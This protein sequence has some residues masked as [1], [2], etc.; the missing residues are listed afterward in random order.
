MDGNIQDL[1]DFQP[2]KSYWAFVFRPLN[3]SFPPSFRENT[4]IFPL[5]TSSPLCHVSW[6]ATSNRNFMAFISL[7]LAVWF[8]L[9]GNWMLIQERKTHGSNHCDCNTLKGE[10]YSSSSLKPGNTAASCSLSKTSLFQLSFQLFLFY[11]N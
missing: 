9:L 5:G 2:W 8:S 6:V 7:S 3:T 11:F 10:S 4:W 1:E